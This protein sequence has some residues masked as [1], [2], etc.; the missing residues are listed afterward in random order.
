MLTFS[1]W[2]TSPRGQ[3][4]PPGI[5]EIQY[6]RMAL[7]CWSSLWS[8]TPSLQNGPVPDLISGLFAG[9]LRPSPA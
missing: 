3:W 6:T 4:H 8:R 5:H 1:A 2:K 7:V 9:N